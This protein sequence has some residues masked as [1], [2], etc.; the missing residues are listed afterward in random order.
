MGNL[1]RPM[2]SQVVFGKNP[3]FVRFSSIFL[4]DDPLLRDFGGAMKGRVECLS[5]GII[6]DLDFTDHVTLSIQSNCPTMPLSP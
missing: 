2:L 4:I 6:I 3:L 5:D 1:I